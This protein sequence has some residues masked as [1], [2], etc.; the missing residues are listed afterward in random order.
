MVNSV[1]GDF[2]DNF[3]FVNILS[4]EGGVIT[5]D[6]PGVIR[7]RLGEDL[8]KIPLSLKLSNGGENLNGFCVWPS[9]ESSEGSPSECLLFDLFED[10]PGVNFSENFV[11]IPLSQR[12]FSGML[13]TRVSSLHKYALMRILVRQSMRVAI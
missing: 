6:P 8:S 10:P 11:C 7:R 5:C 12:I 9:L 4:S 1:G 2:E 13:R 3:F